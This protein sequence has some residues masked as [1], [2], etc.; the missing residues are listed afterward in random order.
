M[1]KMLKVDLYNEER[2]CIQLTLPAAPYAVL[3]ALEKLRLEEKGLCRADR[4]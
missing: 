4:R 2:R 1:H 3:D